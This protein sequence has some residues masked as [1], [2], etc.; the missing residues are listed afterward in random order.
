MMT[1]DREI[2]TVRKKAPYHV[3][4]RTNP[5]LIAVALSAV[6]LAMAGCRRA[7]R[8]PLARAVATSNSYLAS[9]VRDVA[10]PDVPI[11]SL[12]PPGTCPGHFDIRP[13]QVDQLR[14][15]SVLLRFD[16]QR[17]IDAK[18]RDLAGN[19]LQIRSI[20]I[21]GALCEP[22]SYLA[23]CKQAGET[24]A[25]NHVTDPAVL[26][27]QFLRIETQLNAL[28][29][30]ARQQIQ[31]AGLDH[32]PVL[33]SSHQAG[34]CRWLGLNVAAVFSGSDSASLGQIDS[35]I[36]A[37][38]S[39]KARFII[40]NQ[41][42]GR[43]AADALAERLGCRVVMFDNFPP[44]PQAAGTYQDMVRTNV[45]RLVQASQP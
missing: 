28:A 16:F 34:F 43:S 6:L 41:P 8:E 14:H 13:S 37:G 22:A 19:G 45:R 27:Q 3:A 44:S 7:P 31:Q 26:E 23:A 11:I 10:G 33:C 9:A 39:Q 4:R 29:D 21:A 30:Q 42:E 12:A 18:L 17:S 32:R 38:G 1:D 36:R 5:A 2:T 24:L 20:E 35:A 40:G 25:A 15:C